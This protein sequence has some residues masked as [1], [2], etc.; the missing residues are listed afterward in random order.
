MTA[1]NEIVFREVAFIDST[2]DDLATFVAGLRPDVEPSC[3]MARVRLRPRSR[4]P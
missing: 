2:I 4:P 3:S 1:S